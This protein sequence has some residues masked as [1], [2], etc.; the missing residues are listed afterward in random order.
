MFLR[1][2][3]SI[4]VSMGMVVAATAKPSLNKY[5]DNALLANEQ[6]A[7]AVFN[8]GAPVLLM[9]ESRQAAAPVS[10]KE[11]VQ[12]AA[13]GGLAEIKMGELAQEKSDNERVRRF[14]IEVANDYENAYEKLRVAASEMDIK[15]ANNVTA[16]QQQQYDELA[17][18]S[19]DE[20]DRAYIGVKVK[21]LAAIVQLYRLEA[22]KGDASEVQLFAAYIV[23]KLEQHLA[24]AQDI[25]EALKDPDTSDNANQY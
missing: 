1:N 4:L 6:Q 14:A 23:P 19:G 11:F 7:A 13:T 20:F 12:K 9:A 17:K 24:A 5:D 21:D 18:L 16:E 25:D 15:T 22:R 8:A 10:E 3:I 2:A